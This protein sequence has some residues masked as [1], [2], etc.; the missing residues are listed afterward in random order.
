[1]ATQ[2][3]RRQQLTL[4]PEPVDP[5]APLPCQV[6]DGDLWFADS[7]ADLERAKRLCMGCPSRVQCLAGALRREESCGVWGGE[8]VERGVV[9]PFKRPPGRPR[10][11]C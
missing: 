4:V 9:I 7:P 8:I 6:T 1:M 2:L 5:R 3:I 10:K 11:A